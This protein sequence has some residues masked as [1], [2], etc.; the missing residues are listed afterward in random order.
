MGCGTS[1]AKPGSVRLVLPGTQRISEP[2]HEIP[3]G[4]QSQTERKARPAGGGVRGLMLF[5]GS[6]EGLT[7][8]GTL[9]PG[10]PEWAEGG[11]QAYGG[12]GSGQWKEPPQSWDAGACQT[13]EPGG[14]RGLVGPQLLRAW[15]AWGQHWGSEQRVDMIGLMFAGLPLLLCQRLRLR[16]GGGR[17]GDIGEKWW[18]LRW[19]LRWRGHG[20]GR[21]MAG[22]GSALQL[23]GERTKEVKSDCVILGWTFW[24][25][26]AV[27]TE[28]RNGRRGAEAQASRVRSLLASGRAAEWCRGV[29]NTRA[30]PG[31]VTHPRSPGYRGSA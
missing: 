15:R 22:S 24:K 28:M 1:S 18:G 9:S 12:E 29:G 2:A 10:L 16:Q 11:L 13:P 17:C 6:Q 20:R 8:E 14:R 26:P 23:W 5:G 25:V 19:G 7:D 30:G 21:Q 3:D 27:A 4:D 31:H